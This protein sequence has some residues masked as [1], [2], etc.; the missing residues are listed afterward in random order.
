MASPPMS[1]RLSAFCF[2]SKSR[3]FFYFAHTHPLTGVAVPFGVMKFD[4]PKLPT[5]AINN[6]N[7]YL[8]NHARF[9]GGICPEKFQL[10]QIKNGRLLIWPDICHHGWA[11]TVLQTVQ[12]PGVNSAAYGTVHYEEPLKSFE[13]R[14]WLCPSFRLPSVA[15]L[16]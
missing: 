2:R 8:A 12:R 16:I 9:Q 10:D 11:Y 1:G 3:Y 15:I 7:N 14:L 4:L 13:I 6:F 5:V